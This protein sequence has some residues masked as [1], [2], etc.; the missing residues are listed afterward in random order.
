LSGAQM[1]DKYLQLANMAFKSAKY[2]DAINYYEKAKLSMPELS[3]VIDGNI[4]RA[5]Q[6]VNDNHSIQ[7]EKVDG[8]DEFLDSI[9]SKELIGDAKRE[10][11]D[12]NFEEEEYLKGKLHAINVS[13]DSIK[14]SIIMPTFNR[15]SVIEKAL[16]SVINQTH[17]NWELIVVDDGSTDNTM[18]LLSN[19][20]NF[21]LIY[22]SSSMSMFL[23]F[24]NPLF[25]S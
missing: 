13:L 15:A 7:F 17:T 10:F 11:Q 6:L 8:G 14:V 5:K 3:N 20:R 22:S 18:S 1:S 9:F 24:Y 16:R 4:K 2:I 23:F 25:L 21:R 19:Y 12:Y